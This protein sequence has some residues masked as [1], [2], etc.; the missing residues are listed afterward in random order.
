MGVKARW[1]VPRRICRRI[2]GIVPPKMFAMG[3]YPCSLRVVQNHRI[4]HDVALVPFCHTQDSRTHRRSVRG[5]RAHGTKWVIGRD[6]DQ[7]RDQNAIHRCQLAHGGMG[8]QFS[9]N[10]PSNELDRI[11]IPHGDMWNQARASWCA[12]ALKVFGAF[13]QIGEMH[14]ECVRRGSRHPH[15]RCKI[16]I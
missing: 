6:F 15:E 4:P 11:P 5:A 9:G 16:H 8:T 3:A 13:P 7:E 1:P 12:F 10:G 14:A 2:R